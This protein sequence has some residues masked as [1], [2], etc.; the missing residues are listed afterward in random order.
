MP[1]MIKEESTIEWP[2]AG[3][4]DWQMA[5]ELLET[6]HDEQEAGLQQQAQLANAQMGQ[7][8]EADIIAL[9][10]YVWL[11]VSQTQ[12]EV[13]WH[14]QACAE[15]SRREQ[16]LKQ[17]LLAI[18]GL[19]NQNEPPELRSEPAP[20]PP[21]SSPEWLLS[22]DDAPESV[23]D[24]ALWQ[25]VQGLLSWSAVSQSTR[26]T[27]T[28]PAAE[29]I[30]PPIA[31]PGAVQLEQAE[32]GSAALVIYCLGPFRVYL[33]GQPVTGW[34]SLKS[35]T[36]LKYLV[37]HH[38]GSTCKDVLMEVFWPE[39]DPEAARRN[40]HQ[41]IYCLRQTLK[42][43]RADLQPIQFEND[44]YSLNPALTVWLDSAEFERHAQAGRRLEAAGQLAAA[45]A[46][47]SRAEALYQGDFL[48]EDLY[49]DW[50]SWPREHLRSI[51]LDLADRLSEYHLRQGEL[52]TAIALCQKML[53]RDNCYEQAHRR[54]MEC[55]H[56]Q[57]QR[58]LAVRQYQLCVQMLKT[59]LDMP[60]SAETQ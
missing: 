52:E 44:C 59:E 10:R 30:V 11:A 2:T 47:Y 29:N 15:A 42:R 51:Y 36:I 58:H 43:G 7:T 54:L 13:V 21:F 60:L 49:E 12:S 28:L 56:R 35:Q 45:M 5:G 39:A 53:G 57:G 4:L 6:S 40:L 31:P 41:A 17:Q 37:T 50:T 34:N 14:Q 8:A 22:T 27:L 16:Q 55:Y 26:A 25:S 9:L 1:V 38:G 46:E 32:P 24:A 3:Q 18:L 33:N 19:L 23:L 48:E 20:P